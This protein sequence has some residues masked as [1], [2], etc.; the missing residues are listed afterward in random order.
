MTDMVLPE[1]MTP[2]D[3]N[4]RGLSCMPLDTV[5]LLQSDLYALSSGDEFKAAVTLWCRAWYQ[6]PAGS[7]PD[8]DRILASL[9]QA[10]PAWVSVRDMALHGWVKCSDGRLYHPVLALKVLNE[11]RERGAQCKEEKE[12]ALDEFF[13]IFN[14]D[15]GEQE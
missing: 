1:P 4:L 6:V 15:A 7:L 8:N 5:A 13:G 14:D 10:G 3:C 2:P 12:A 11:W 9:S